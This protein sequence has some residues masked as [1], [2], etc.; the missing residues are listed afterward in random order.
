MTLYRHLVL[1]QTIPEKV[2]I[3]LDV[4]LKENVPA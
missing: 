2:E 1:E 3:P 4:Y